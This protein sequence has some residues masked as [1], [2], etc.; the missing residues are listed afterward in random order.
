MGGDKVFDD[1]DD[2]NAVTNLIVDDSFEEED[3]VN[4]EEFQNGSSEKEGDP[5]AINNGVSADG[6]N[7]SLIE[8]HKKRELHG[9]ATWNESNCNNL[10]EHEGPNGQAEDS[11][12]TE[13][14]NDD[15]RSRDAIDRAIK[16]SRFQNVKVFNKMS[17]NSETR[18]SELGELANIFGTFLE[19]YQEH[20]SLLGEVLGREAAAE[21][22]AGEKRA[23]LNGELSK[24]PNLN[25]QTRLRAA[26]LIVT[27]P[28]KLDLFYS[29][30]EEERREWVSMLLSGLI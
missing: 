17:F 24:L 28:A 19:K 11:T 16:R 6:A 2:N 26:S 30:S 14:S 20:L 15:N 3:R 12:G 13:G 27:D 29:L 25:L 7:Y 21:K 5:M 23:R 1:D 22:R 8:F 4:N 18:A 9:G 10:P